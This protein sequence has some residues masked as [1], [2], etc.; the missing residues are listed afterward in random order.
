MKIT[1]E[2]SEAEVKGLKDYLKD[3]DLKGSKQDIA[4]HIENIIHG[5]INAPQES[6]SQY[7]NKYEK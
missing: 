3:A 1:I 6:S 4:A 2:L 5:V 7:I